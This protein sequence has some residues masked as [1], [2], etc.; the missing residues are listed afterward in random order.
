MF[1]FPL[2]ATIAIAALSLLAACGGGTTTS[3]SSGELTEVTIGSQQVAADAGLFLADQLGYFK[4]AGIKATFQR[5]NDASVI[6]NSLA[7][8][9][10]DV[11]G[12]T[13]TP[14]TYQSTAK[15][16]GIKIVGD[17]NFQAPARGTLPAMSA[18]RLAV[19]PQYDKGNLAATLDALRGKKIAIHS[20]QSIQIVYTDMLLRKY[21]F[22][23][24]DFQITPV[25]SPNQT[26][27]LQNGAIDA[28]VMQEPYFSQAV[29]AGIVKPA[30]DMTEELPPNGASMTALLFGK[31]F[32][33]EKDTA[34]KFMT[35]YVRGVRAYNDAMF[36][37]KD[38]DKVVGIVANAIGVPPAQLA[39]T[40]PAGLDPEQSIDLTWLQTCQDFYR[41]N[42]ML[43]AQVNVADMV[44]TSFR[45]EAVKELG[46]YAPP[47]S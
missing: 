20:D 13:I 39:N 32:L 15:N 34:Q 21:G 9:H 29:A 45:D 2:R 22:S 28:A 31:E 11:A 26:A 40:Y 23:R 3:S 7:T 36:Y 41:S 35:A 10:L 24:S 6:T 5:M 14:G 16:L 25:L 12:A 47:K 4:D 17:K 33:A 43:D 19:K 1:R 18:T 44:D 38:K 46:P 8:G 42:G 27:A 30:S 37:G